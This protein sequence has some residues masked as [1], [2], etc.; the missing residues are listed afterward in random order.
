METNRERCL[1][2]FTAARSDRRKRRCS[3]GFIALFVGLTFWGELR[4]GGGEA[5]KPA[6]PPATS[7]VEF[8]VERSHLLMCH[9]WMWRRTLV[10]V[11]LSLSAAG[12]RT[13]V[14][15]WK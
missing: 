8:Q 10:L 12:S 9:L 14:I 15:S 11:A 4:W 7:R 2:D 6:R 13:S 5:R 3:I 1:R